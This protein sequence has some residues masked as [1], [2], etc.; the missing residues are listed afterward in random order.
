MTMFTTKKPFLAVVLSLTIALSFIALIQLE[1]NNSMNFNQMVPTATNLSPLRLWTIPS[2]SN[3]P[4]IEST[5]RVVQPAL[6]SNSTRAQIYEFI[7]ANPGIEFRGICNGLG[8]AIGTA[9]FHLGV[10][11]KAG[12]ISFFRDGKYK[13]FFVSKAFLNQDIKL[14]SLLRHK[15]AREIIKKLA[16]EKETSH[17]ILASYLS[18]TSQG[19]TWQM[20]RLK[21]EGIVEQKI[22][23]IKVSYSLNQTYLQA[24]PELLNIAEKSH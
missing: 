11:R 24:L 8:I 2:F 14:I 13:R 10:L 1:K 7:V 6:I 18:I 9:E 3:Q 4:V 20:N 16:L 15:T 5:I 22:E 23:G 19:L 21:K 12:L 17:G